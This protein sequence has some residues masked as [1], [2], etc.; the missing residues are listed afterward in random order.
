M[1]HTPY[2]GK[3]MTAAFGAGLASFPG[4]KKITIS[5]KAR[6][7]PE[8]FDITKATDSAYT[9]LADPL[10]GKGKPLTTV[11]VEGL[12]SKSDV[13]DS[14]PFAEALNATANVTVQPTGNTAT[15][16]QFVCNSMELTSLTRTDAIRERALYTAVMEVEA[17]G[18]WSA[19]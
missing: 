18:E 13:G 10:G 7:L 14:G 16:N 1:A 5:E 6:D 3:N 8:Q 12:A 19:I 11:T 15:N 2:T 17:V 4:V 9:Y